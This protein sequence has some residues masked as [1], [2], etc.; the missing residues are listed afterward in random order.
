MRAN[1]VLENS[2]IL[3]RVLATSHNLRQTRDLRRPHFSLFL[4]YPS[5]GASVQ[6]LGYDSG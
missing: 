5:N 1:Y 4:Y 2:T 6:F 3:H